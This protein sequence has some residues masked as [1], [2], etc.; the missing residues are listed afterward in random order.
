MK[1]EKLIRELDPSLDAVK[2]KAITDIYADLTSRSM[3]DNLNV[4]TVS[5]MRQAEHAIKQ[6]M[7]V[8]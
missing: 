3:V 7:G 4:Q 6:V 8:K 5:T 1:M 2:A